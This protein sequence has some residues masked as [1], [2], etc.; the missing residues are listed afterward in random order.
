[1]RKVEV[2]NYLVI[3]PEILA[4]ELAGLAELEVQMGELWISDRAHVIMPYHKIIDGLEE[5]KKG[6][7][8]AGTTR[9]GIGPCYSDKMSRFGLCRLR[10]ISTLI[11]LKTVMEI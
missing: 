10:L 1:M 6:K 3:D 4:K 11:I 9:R 2:G 5:E 8:A 7:L